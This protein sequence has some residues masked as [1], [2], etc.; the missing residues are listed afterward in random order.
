[1]PRKRHVSRNADK[2]EVSTEEE[3]VM[4]RKRHVSRN[5]ISARLKF[6]Q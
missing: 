6:M 3:E 2:E 1:M 5:I 4:P